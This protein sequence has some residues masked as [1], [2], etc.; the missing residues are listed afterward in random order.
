VAAALTSSAQENPLPPLEPS[1]VISPEVHADRRVTFRLR[2]PN[3]KQVVLHLEGAKPLPMEPDDQGV[4]SVTTEALEP[5]FYG[6]EFTVDG[7]R[8]TDP[9]N[10]VLKP[11]LL[12]VSSEV[13]VPGP[14]SLPWELNPTLHGVVH[15]HFY[16]AAMTEISTY[17]LHPVT[18]AEGER[19]IPFFIC[20]M[21]TAMMPA[22]GRRSA[23]P[24]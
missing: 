21:A 2:A 19:S 22:D 9:S 17:T 5:D 4:S 14:G 12:A 8:F 11:N 10:T 13:H 1:P 20:S 24:T 7:V 18:R 16:K 3:S 6:Y 23:A 15:H